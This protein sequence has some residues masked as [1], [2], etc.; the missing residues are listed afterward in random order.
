M[1]F[2]FSFFTLL[3][4][5]SIRLELDN[6]YHS[7]HTGM[8][9]LIRTIKSSTVLSNVPVNL[10]YT[11]NVYIGSSRQLF[12][13]V[14]DTG[15]ADLWVPSVDCELESCKR[16]IRYNPSLSNTASSTGR[17]FTMKYGTGEVGGNI[18]RD[19]IGILLV[20][21]LRICWFHSSTSANWCSSKSV[22]I[23]FK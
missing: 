14:I 1:N 22:C 9:I 15:S 16:H 19:Q 4:N 8:S 17:I 5:A 6:A 12:K 13:V 11:A 2:I 21:N 3:V 10:G 23:F 18:F 20:I 7:D